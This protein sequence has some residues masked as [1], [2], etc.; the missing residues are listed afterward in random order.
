M[1]RGGALAVSLVAPL[2]F[3]CASEESEPV[4]ATGCTDAAE[5]ELPDG[6]CIRPGIGPD[7]C[8]PGFL[9][10]GQYG[11]DP[12]LPPAPCPAGQMALPGETECRSLMPCGEGVWGE[13][14]IE[15]DTQY[16]DASYGGGQ[17]DGSAERPWTTI[18]A[19]YQAAGSGSMIAVAEGSYAEA[20]RI[21]GKPVRIWGRCPER[22]EIVGTTASTWTV[23]IRTLATATELHGIAVGGPI[24][25]IGLSGSEGVVL[26]RVWIRETGDRGID[27]EGVLGTTSITI[28]GSLVEHTREL[29]VAIIGATA[30]IE[31]SVVRDIQPAALGEF[32]RGIVVQACG[33]AR[34]CSPQVVG[35]ATLR[36]SIIERTRQ[37]GLYV[38]GGE[39]IAE[40]I[41][42]RDTVP[43]DSDP[44]GGRGISVQHCDPADGC[45]LVVRGKA[46]LRYS[47]VERN[48]EYGV[49]VSGSDA[50]A[51]GLVVRDTQPNSDQMQG[52]GINVQLSCEQGGCDPL[53]RSSATVRS[54]L[55]ERNH[56]SA[57]FV[58]GSDAIVEDVV[59][60]T[61]MP[62]QL[63][64][65]RGRGIDVQ[66]SCSLTGCDAAARSAATIRR[67]FVVDNHDVGVGVFGSDITMEQSFVRG[68]RARPDGLFGDGLDVMSYFA[69]ASAIVTNTRIDHN[70]RAGIAS[71]GASV[72]LGGTELTC[73]SINL[74]GQSLEGGDFV[75][76]DLGGNACGCDALVDSC[77]LVGATL[78]PPTQPD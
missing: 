23:D 54:S 39:L 14:P 17:S 38:G 8:A 58:M 57:V 35:T 43:Q 45:D 56:D 53:M 4:L 61:T 70:V 64:Q 40:G 16:V 32:G 42:I 12:V 46:T 33:A 24:L 34:D 9:H 31:D 55:I 71:F 10:D 50:T 44:T 63:S 15:P 26:D 28:G 2:F 62:A 6:T 7:G 73:N 75:F 76:E 21:E 49:F 74:S 19:A 60:R 65:F 25:G 68:T 67:A 36:H 51:E 69:P 1:G 13:I 59:V 78:E 3:A 18:A 5:V 77:T 66:L 29:G 37:A 48:H 41:L 22:V 52:Q 47:V 20:L 72:T 30:T 11:C 27:V